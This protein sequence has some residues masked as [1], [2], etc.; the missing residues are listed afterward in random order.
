MKTNDVL[1]GLLPS[2]VLRAEFAPGAS[3]SLAQLARLCAPMLANSSKRNAGVVTLDRVSRPDSQRGTRVQWTFKKWQ[4]AEVEIAKN[5]LQERLQRA[6]LPWVL[7]QDIRFEESSS[8]LNLGADGVA[9]SSD[10]CLRFH[11]PLRFSPTNPAAAQPRLDSQTFLTLATTR[12]EELTHRSA[13]WRDSPQT[14]TILPYFGQTQWDGPATSHHG[15]RKARFEGSLFIRGASKELASAIVAMQ[16][17]HLA[18]GADAES[19][20]WH[21][22]YIIREQRQ[23]WL[24]HCLTK[25]HALA[26]TAYR[27][28]KEQDCAPVLAADGRILEPVEV[29]DQLIAELRAGRY[30]PQPSEAFDLHRPGHA[31]RR[32]ERLATRDL[33]LQ[34]HA[35]Q[36]LT[37]VFEL[38]FEPSSFGFRPGLSRQDALE[39]VRAALRSGMHQVL[40]TDVEQCFPSIEHGVLRELIDRNLLRADTAM[41]SVLALAMAQPYLHE[42]QCHQRSCGLP[43]G[44][45]LS[46]ILA[47][48]ALTELDRAL[49]CQRI[50]YVRYADDLV[51]LARTRRDAQE[52][53]A[54]IEGVM[55]Q[56]HLQLASHKTRITHL[57]AGFTFLGETFNVAALESR[58][59]CVPAQRKPMIVTEPFLQLGINGD[60]LEARREGA[61][62]GV[63]PLRRLSEILVLDRVN[64]SSALLDRCDKF[65][66]P[67]ALAQRGGK[68]VNVVGGGKP[69]FLASQYA[70]AMWHH[71]L[72]P[73][74]LLALAKEVVDTKLHN[75]AQLVA[76][77][78]GHAELVQQIDEVRRQVHASATVAV[79]RG[80]EGHVAKLMFTWLKAQIVPAQRQHFSAQR[81]SR[82]GPDRL[83]S[84]LNFLY[85]LLYV[86]VNGLVRLLGL[87]PYLGWLHDAQD[88]SYETLVYDLMEPLRPF[89]DR[90][91]LRL[92]NRQELR[93]THFDTTAGELRLQRATARLVADR[94]EEAMGERMQGVPLR[95]L[96]WHQLQ[97]VRRLAD[98]QG[99]LWLLRWRPRETLFASDE[100]QVLALDTPD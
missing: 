38:H 4:S 85:F 48:L 67:I 7:T 97:S 56:S 73:A 55:K 78:R 88:C 98:Q 90:V 69:K 89:V 65:D 75:Q 37:P 61:L 53:L 71:N 6:D 93:A 99:S 86:R 35:L 84:L 13:P 30:K 36:I 72:E 87:N 15:N 45:P 47:N 3:P 62:L 79:L 60:A 94:F 8:P 57:Q 96:L 34:Q 26:Q 20:V 10:L 52:A 54:T 95:E 25:R 32:V 1:A 2:A 21:A 29:A 46:P 77:R 91:A 59:Q 74:S 12:F 11:T 58:P 5:Q 33:I 23:P 31:P 42:G 41:R 70:H 63:W 18:T 17:W 9:V 68:H 82:G 76:Q 22:A 83:N 44:A 19:V 80:H 43:Q 28:L 64:L 16:P 49:D 27:V 24:D 39:Q 92:V 100:P 40:E 14:L 50:R 51:V 66:I 81:R